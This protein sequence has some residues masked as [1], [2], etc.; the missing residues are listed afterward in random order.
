MSHLP[1]H[2]QGQPHGFQPLHPTHAPQAVSHAQAYT[3]SGMPTS[4]PVA[5]EASMLSVSPARLPP[6]AHAT[7]SGNGNGYGTST[8]PKLSDLVARAEA[9]I[10]A[11]ERLGRGAHDATV[12]STQASNDLQERLRLGVRMLQAFDVQIQRSEQTSGNAGMQAAAQFTNQA[13]AVAQQCE[14]RVRAAMEALE[15]RLAESVPFL[16]ERLRLAHEQVGRIVEERLGMAERRIDD[17]YG[18]ARDELRRYADEVAADFAQRLETTLQERLA[19]LPPSPP[20]SNGRDLALPIAE[21]E[22]RVRSLLSEAERRSNAIEQT[23]SHTESRVRRLIDESTEAADALLGTVGTAATLKDLVA[24]ECHASRRMAD[25]AQGV[26]RE[27]QRDMLEVVEKCTVVRS[28][29]KHE[30]QEFVDASRNVEDRA[31]S[32]TGLQAELDTLLTRLAPW[33]SLVR[34]E[35]TPMQQV[36]ESISSGVRQTIGEDMRSFS[37][38]LR[39]LAGRAE[40]AFVSARFDEFSAVTESDTPTPTPTPATTP[41]QVTPQVT[42]QVHQATSPIDTRRLTAEIMALDASSLLRPPVNL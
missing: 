26:A 18:P 35:G 32:L 1:T 22:E 5:V 11:L 27:L 41:P 2:D 6:L 25:E 15:R 14:I 37:Q 42:T 19:A 16:D 30:M 28:T 40:H 24:E 21:M 29:V 9:S 34:R 38:A 13:N 36:V 7:G 3:T 33:E 20:Q 23:L 31:A 10:D 17:R 8:Q 4:M 39:Q 12:A